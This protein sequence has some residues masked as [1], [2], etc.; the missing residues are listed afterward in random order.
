MLSKTKPDV[1]RIIHY[2]D[3]HEFVSAYDIIEVNSKINA[4][5]LISNYKKS[6]D[7]F[8]FTDVKYV[9]FFWFQNEQEYI[10]DNW[11]I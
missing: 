5:E 4:E 7:K 3:K 11:G 9:T 6:Y 2:N 1:L 8:G 10:C